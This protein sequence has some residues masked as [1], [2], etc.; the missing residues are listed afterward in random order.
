MKSLIMPVVK[1]EYYCKLQIDIWIP[2]ECGSDEFVVKF[3][4]EE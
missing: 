2:N 1:K 4:L 3:F